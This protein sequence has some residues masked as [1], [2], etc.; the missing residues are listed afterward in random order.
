MLFDFICFYYNITLLFW[1]LYEYDILII[2]AIMNSTFGIKKAAT[3]P[4]QYLPKLSI[5]NS[6]VPTVAKNK[7]FKIS[8]PLFQFYHG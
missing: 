6:M 2:A 3:S 8:R 4:C 7:S 1:I 5:N